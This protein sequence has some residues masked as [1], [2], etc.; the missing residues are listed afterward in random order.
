MTHIGDSRTQTQVCYTLTTEPQLHVPWKISEIQQ[1]I[2]ALN[3]VT[4]ID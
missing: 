1:Q 4:E 2:T 3:A